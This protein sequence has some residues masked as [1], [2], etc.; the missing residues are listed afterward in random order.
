MKKILLVDDE[1]ALTRVIRLNL[2][3]T[4]RFEVREENRGANAV[5]VAREF[6]PDLIFL[7]VMMPDM[8]GDEIAAEL[9]EDPEL[10]NIKYVFLTAIVTK[11]ETG[12]GAAEISGKTFLA[13]PV[14]RNELLAVIDALIGD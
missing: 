10:R 1:A 14:K 2:E 7:D 9:D 6:M 13:K 4:G 8:G 3:Q 5:R 12:V 11:S